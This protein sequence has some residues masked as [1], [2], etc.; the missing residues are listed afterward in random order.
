MNNPINRLFI[1]G[2]L[3]LGI[4]IAMILENYISKSNST[5]EYII[6]IT[7]C[8]FSILF[9]IAGTILKIKNK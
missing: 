2:V 1:Y 8:G 4:S 3:G 7:L 5:L 6:G 9:L